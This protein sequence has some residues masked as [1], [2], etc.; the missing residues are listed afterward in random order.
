A[1]SFD[2]LL[3]DSLKS[4]SLGE[5]VVGDGLGSVVAVFGGEGD[6][7]SQPRNEKLEAISNQPRRATK[8]D[9]VLT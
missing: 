6:L 9:S 1:K 7:E 8:K 3:S 4:S 2:A 5:G